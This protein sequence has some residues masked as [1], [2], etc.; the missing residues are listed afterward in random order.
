MEICFTGVLHTL[1]RTFD[2]GEW[3]MS[4]NFHERDSHLASCVIGHHRLNLVGYVYYEI[5]RSLN[6][7]FF[8]FL[9]GIQCDHVK[10]SPCLR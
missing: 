9:P 2:S 10:V 1:S 6:F 8:L 3:T 4:C 5:N 7:P